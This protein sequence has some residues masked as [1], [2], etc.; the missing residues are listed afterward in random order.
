[1]LQSERV[2]ANDLMIN[3]VE[4]EA[5]EM[6]TVITEESEEE[7]VVEEDQEKKQEELYM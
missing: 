6:E 3:E 7:E 1:M 2:L 5:H 4:E